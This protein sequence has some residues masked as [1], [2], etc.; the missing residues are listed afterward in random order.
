[1]KAVE[2]GAGGTIS[3]FQKEE[4]LKRVR[5][6]SDE[7]ILKEKTKNLAPKW[8]DSSRPGNGKKEKAERVTHK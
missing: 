5:N 2:A 1:M 3:R 4:A 8:E 7:K 6:N